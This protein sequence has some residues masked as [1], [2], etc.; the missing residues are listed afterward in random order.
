MFELVLF[1]PLPGT[2]AGYCNPVWHKNN[3]HWCIKEKG[4]NGKQVLTATCCKFDCW[5]VGLV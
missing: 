1:N 4:T 5:V 2:T 3:M